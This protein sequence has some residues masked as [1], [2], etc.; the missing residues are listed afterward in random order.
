MS[1][2]YLIVIAHNHIILQ[3]ARS[4][5]QALRESIAL[6]DIVFNAIQTFRL[7]FASGRFSFEEITC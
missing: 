5:E 7:T 6:F 2:V 1:Q 3:T 4:N